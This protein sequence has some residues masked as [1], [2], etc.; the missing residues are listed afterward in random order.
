MFKSFIIKVFSLLVAVVLLIPAGRGSRDAYDVKDPEKCRLNFSVLSDAHIEGNNFN[1]YKV[2]EHALQNVKCNKSGNDA[3][4]FLGDNT[5]NGQSIESMLFYGT[6][7]QQ[8]KNETVLPVLGNHDVG[9]GEG[10]YQKLQARWYDYMAACVGRKLSHPYYSDVIDGY[11]F[12]VLGMEK[13]E[14]HEMYVSDEQFAWLEGE[15]EKAAKSG[16]PTFVFS[17]YPT[18][19][20]VD[21]DGRYTDRL[22]DLLAEF[23]KTNDLFCFVGHTHMPLMLF[24]SFHTSDGFP[25]IYL[26]RLTDLYGENDNEI[27]KRSG[28]GIEVEVY[29][30]EVT[31]RGRNFYTGKWLVDDED[32]GEL[33][34]VTYQLKNPVA[35]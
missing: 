4:V 23:N 13:Q 29:E 34:E 1:R 10:N 16:K 21:A 15:L 30:T 31:V 3:V 8:M 22:T 2:F 5:M 19:D 20:V 28:I 12:I 32:T 33:C 26:P 24:W 17:H 7:A 25:E 14:V 18:D 27:G 9:N 6:L 11:Y 35:A